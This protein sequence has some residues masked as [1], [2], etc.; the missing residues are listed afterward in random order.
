MQDYVTA[1]YHLKKAFDTKSFGSSIDYI[2]T[3]YLMNPDTTPVEEM[4]VGMLKTFP[5][6]VHQEKILS[7][8]V[9][10]LIMTKKDL[11]QALKYVP[12]LLNIKSV[13][14]LYSLQVNNLTD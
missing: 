11:I 1:N 5:H 6:A 7:Q 4:L 12:S 13:T 10:Y 14:C 3:L 2:Y 9:S 8:I